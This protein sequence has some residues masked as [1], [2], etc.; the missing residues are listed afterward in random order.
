MNIFSQSLQAIF[1]SSDLQKLDIKKHQKYIIHQ[2]LQYGDI[3]DYYWLKQQYT[4]EEIQ[5]IFIE[6]P[7]PIYTLKSFNFTKNYLLNLENQK[8]DQQKYVSN[9]FRRH[10]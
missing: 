7:E 3:K 9:S 2:I 6:Q 10:I 4:L 8:L 1:W 5:R